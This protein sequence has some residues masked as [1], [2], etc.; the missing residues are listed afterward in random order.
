[1]NFRLSTPLQIRNFK[2]LFTRL[3][4]DSD[5]QTIDWSASV[6]AREN[7][8]ENLEDLKNSYPQY[9]WEDPE[10]PYSDMAVNQLRK[11]AKDYGYRLVEASELR[12]LH[13]IRKNEEKP[14][15]QM[16][17]IPKSTKPENSEPEKKEEAPKVEA[18][19]PSALDEM[20]F[21]QSTKK[22]FDQIIYDLSLKHLVML[23]DKGHGKTS[24][25]KA[26]IQYIKERMGDRISVKVFDL[27]QRWYHGAPLKWR[28]W[29][30]IDRYRRGLIRNVDDCV[31]EIGDLSQDDRRMFV[32]WII[33]K[34]YK[35]RYRIG[36]R[37]G[38]EA[39]EE[40]PLIVYVFEEANAYFKSMSIKGGDA[41][42][43]ALSDFAF[44]GRNYGLTGISIVLFEVGGFST[45]F[46][47]ISNHLYGAVESKADR[48]MLRREIDKQ[49]AKDVSPEKI[50]RFYWYYRGTKKFGPFRIFDW[51]EGCG[52]PEDYEPPLYARG[53]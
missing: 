49:L 35:E 20:M 9:T 23:A 3:N 17:K 26:I 25:A 4:P 51:S 28:Q 15:E 36:I 1:M 24:S 32:A 7:S 48:G 46:R 39:I 52:T 16:T 18:V 45:D 31:Y 47:R 38:I 22:V 42:A 33:S 43:R 2:K 8:D 41:A 34:D 30:T 11:E 19:E 53:L 14:A 13:R 5:P 6:G 10:D 12:R 50:K 44:V 37:R 40:Q 21:D 27:S 29:V